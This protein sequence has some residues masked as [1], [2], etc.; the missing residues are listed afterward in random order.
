MAI[1]RPHYNGA[2]LRLSTSGNYCCERQKILDDVKEYYGKTLQSSEDLKT[3]DCT[4]L[5]PIPQH[6]R[7]SLE[8]VH[9]D[10]LSRFY[11]CGLVV[12][13]CVESCSILD[14][15]SGSGRD[16]YML[17]KLVG[18]NGHI[19]GVDMTE[20]LLEVA[21][22][23]T[24]YHTEKFG[25]K[26]SNVDFIYGYI[27]KLSEAGLKDSSFDIIISNGVVNLTP[28]KTAV[29]KEAWR[30]LKDGG[31]MYFSDVYANL[32]LPQ[33]LRGHS[34]LWG[35]CLGGAL[36]WKEL[37][38][39]AQEV[40]FSTPRLVT[41][42]PFNVDNKDLLELLGDY[43]FVSATFRLFKI[44]PD[45]PRTKCEVIYNGSVRGCEQQL[46]FDANYTFQAGEVVEVDEETAAI[47]KNSRFA[48]KFTIQP[49][50][51]SKTA[52]VPSGQRC[53]GQSKASEKNTHGTGV[54]SAGFPTTLP[55]PYSGRSTSRP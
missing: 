12:P 21:R 27:E 52:A 14:M 22:K 23:Y 20:E 7:E 25:Y 13:E 48:A 44:P 17:S 54:N 50:S 6:V 9:Q 49:V 28:D 53:S 24:D 1:W 19:T 39:I 15:G 42:R 5:K 29:L 16:S 45:C 26:K 18:E 38:R 33:E 31:E 34:V 4:P 37:L 32:N 8:E 40:G 47:L 30:V 55:Q 51:T 2:L 11:G 10:V 36:W 41:A 43:K 46:E 3:C 35:E